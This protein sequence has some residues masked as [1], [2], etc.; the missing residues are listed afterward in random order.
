[1]AVE[2]QIR[3]AQV[4]AKVEEA[5][6][7]HL[8]VGHGILLKTAKLVGCGSDTV[9]RVRREMAAELPKAA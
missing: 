9:Q 4:A 7:G 1:M 3:L 5:I 8:S 2:G 6:R